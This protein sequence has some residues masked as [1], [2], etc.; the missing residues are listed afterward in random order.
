MTGEILR[1]KSFKHYGRKG[2]RGEV[3][4]ISAQASPQPGKHFVVA[5]LAQVP[6]DMEITKEFI[7]QRMDL[8]GWKE[9]ED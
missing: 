2:A 7:A 8:L 6:E 1:L 3:Q 4:F 5:M 9:K